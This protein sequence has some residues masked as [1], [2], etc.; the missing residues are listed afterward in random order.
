MRTRSRGCGGGTAAC[1]GS[2]EAGSL[3][4][5]L[6]IPRGEV[7]GTRGL[8]VLSN[9]VVPAAIIEPSYVQSRIVGARQQCATKALVSADGA[10]GVA[11]P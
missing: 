4:I 6:V 11:V 1:C 7:K 8:H 2:D 10:S 9:T 3:P 5:S